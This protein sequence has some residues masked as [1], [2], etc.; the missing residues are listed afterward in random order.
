MTPGLSSSYLKPEEESVDA[1]LQGVPWDEARSKRVSAQASG[2]VSELR[3]QKK[4]ASDLETFFT[5]YGLDT[6]EGLALMSMA[7][8]LLRIPDTATATALIRDKVAATNWL[9]AG[10]GNKDFLS[11]AAGLGLQL[12]GG[13]MTSLFSKMGEPLIRNAMV[14]AMRLLGRQ[15]VIGQ[16][17]ENALKNSKRPENLPYRMS[18]DMLGEG[19][20]TVETAER[21]FDSYRH[22]IESIGAKADGFERRP[23]ISVKLSALH[24]RYEFAQKDRCVPFL[25][26]RLTALCEL[27]AQHN[28]TLTV[29]AEEAERLELSLLVIEKTLLALQ[30]T[31]WDGFGLAVQAYQKRGYPLIDHIGTLA[32]THKRKLQVRL[33]KGAYWDT[34][35]KRAQVL[36]LTGYP[37][38]TRKSNTDLSYL[39]CAHKML[40][41]DY[42]DP[43]FATHN[44]HTIFSILDMA[45][46]RP[47]EFQKLFGM[48][49]AVYRRFMEQELGKVSIYAPVGVHEDLLPYLV[50]RLLENG[51]NSSF[52]KMIYDADVPADT[53]AAD[54]VAKAKSNEQKRHPKIPL[55]AD[56]YGDARKNS[57]GLD[58]TDRASV[59][60][61]QFAME[62]AHR[63]SNKG[64]PLIGGKAIRTSVTQPV[65]NPARTE[66]A[67]GEVFFAELDIVPKA[68][69]TAKTGHV[70]WSK[71]EASR[72]AM[73]LRG[74]ADLL[75]QNRTELMMLCVKEAGKTLDDARDEVRE[76]IDFCRYYAQQGEALFA[77]GGVRMPGPTGESNIYKHESR[78]VFVCIS[79][80]NFP[81]AIFTGQIAAA[82]MAGNAVIAKPA[83]QTPLIAFKAVELMLKAGVPREVIT[84]MPGDGRIGAALVAHAE[85]AGV[86]FTGSTDV[87]WEINRTLAAKDGP[88]V[89]LIAETG[90]QNAFIADSSA[91]AEQVVDDVIHSAFGSAGQRCSA[92]RVLFVQDDAADVIL[93]MLAGAM[94]ELR[95]G[96]PFDIASDIGPV[97][98]EEA[99]SI[100]RRHRMKL[101]GFGKKIAEVPVDE[102]LKSMGNFFAPCA[103]EIDALS[104]LTKE[105]FGPILHVIRYKAAE[106]DDVIE[107][108]NATGYGLTLGIHSRIDKTVQR[109]A[110]N[111]KAG[112]VYVNRSTTGAVVGVQ[113]FGGRGLSGTGPKA[114]GPDY[115]RAFASEKHVSTDIT[116]AGGNASLVMLSE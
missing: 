18:Y 46:G 63:K 35:I 30:Q 67:V 25:A 1:L 56:I 72:R 10:A 40:R 92:A 97:I 82:L 91:L 59:S 6:A 106:L 83:E 108:I 62:R 79:P 89:P 65:F 58:L 81:L 69:E 55:P 9:K 29:D 14:Q 99:R 76:A 48:G 3:L 107:Q 111:V 22:A 19:A 113:P 60:S 16:S 78:G 13:T 43:L 45:E 94:L 77:E 73:I 24:P 34:E 52:V 66:E 51:A 93:P 38:F 105:V 39:A 104:S 74:Y 7:E 11:R 101:D 64:A 54:P 114:G 100:L 42:I 12:T 37:V 90:G 44:V 49:N 96:D 27:A 17:I 21:Y 4:S 31:E 53:L 84:L 102:D 2:F 112:N 8:A 70:I 87:A 98:D 68:F 115:L 88:I 47:M 33:V 61:L 80:W 109:I 86:A 26:E 95:V 71:M 85:T 41:H 20:R 23:G 110:R 103:Y 28:L 15:F 75:Q 50:R 57:E 116:A 36:G 5:H 32:K